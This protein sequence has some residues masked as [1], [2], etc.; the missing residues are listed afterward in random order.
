MIQMD[1][2]GKWNFSYYLFNRKGSFQID[3][4]ITD[5]KD[6]LKYARDPLT[7]L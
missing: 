6:V 2:K 3:F 5:V 4:E 1:L 7:K